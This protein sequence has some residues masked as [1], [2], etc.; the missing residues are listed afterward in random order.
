MYMNTEIPGQY[1]LIITLPISI[2][3]IPIDPTTTQKVIMW[4]HLSFAGFVEC[5]DT[6]VWEL[7]K[8]NPAMSSIPELSQQGKRSHNCWETSLNAR[9]GVQMQMAFCMTADYGSPFAGIEINE[10]GPSM[11]KRQV[12]RLMSNTESCASLSYRI[13]TFIPEHIRLLHGQTGHTWGALVVNNSA[14]LCGTIKEVN[15]SAA[16]GFSNMKGNWMVSHSSKKI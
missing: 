3:F 11:L 14:G 10:T 12:I 1:R 4:H 2:I 15:K 9:D 6:S 8:P 5:L 16:L 7:H 13:K